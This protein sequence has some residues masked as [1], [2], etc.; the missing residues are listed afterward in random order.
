V[1]L[2]ENDRRKIRQQFAI[3]LPQK[4][5]HAQGEILN[6]TYHVMLN[7]RSKFSPITLPNICKHNIIFS[8][9]LQQKKQA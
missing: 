9:S 4:T 5:E 3:G 8:F 6:V 7:K 2:I 1:F